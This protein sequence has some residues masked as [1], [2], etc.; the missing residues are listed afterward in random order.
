MYGLNASALIVFCGDSCLAVR[1]HRQSE[2]VRRRTVTALCAV[3]LVE[4]MLR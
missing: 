4:N 3:M 2:K 1:R